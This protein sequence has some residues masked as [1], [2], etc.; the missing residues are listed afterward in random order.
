MTLKSHS[1]PE[2]FLC[3]PPA[4]LA[5]PGEPKDPKHN[6]GL[7]LAKWCRFRAL[8]SRESVTP[9]GSARPGVRA[10]MKMSPH[11]QRGDFGRQWTEAAVRDTC[12]GTGAQVSLWSRPNV[13]V[14]GR[15]RPRPSSLS[16][17]SAAGVSSAFSPESDPAKSW[18]AGRVLKIDAPRER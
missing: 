2:G 1:T 18:F 14:P 6:A 12:E 13:G 3:Q 7:R 5:E 17:R 16:D 8:E 9:N 4:R 15:Q 10:R 11:E